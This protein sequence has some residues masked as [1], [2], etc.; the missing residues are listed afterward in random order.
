M[1]EKFIQ[2]EQIMKR[3]LLA[4][5]AVFVIWSV[6]DLV[7]HGMVLVSAYLATSQLWRPMPEMKMGLMHATVL[8]TAAAFVLIYAKLISEK[9][10]RTGVIYGALFG[11]GVGVSMGLGSYSVMPLTVSIALG[12]LLGSVVK[13]IIGGWAMGVIV[14]KEA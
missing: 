5:A 6:I 2:G 3:I 1:A 11:T 12:W 13:S 4:V 8:L 14:K 9:S 7:L 10:V